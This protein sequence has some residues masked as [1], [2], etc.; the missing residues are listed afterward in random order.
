M[1]TR[2]LAPDDVS[3]LIDLVRRHSGIVL[4]PEKAYLFESRLLPVANRFDC[5]DLRC[6]IARLRKGANRALVDATVDA[7][8]INETS[9][10]R[11]SRP[12]DQFRRQLLP[13]L[14]ERRA[15]VRRLR[16]WSAAAST[17]Q[18][19]YSLAM[20]IEQYADRLRGWQ[21]EIL[22]SD[23]SASAIARAK[24][25]AYSQFEVQRG[26]P[27]PL[28]VRFFTQ[29]GKQWQVKPE[30]KKYVRFFEHNLLS[31]PSF[32]GS[33][34][35]VFLRNVLIYMDEATR[36]KIVRH[37]LSRLAP[38]GYLVVGSTESLAGLV[39]ELE[40]VPGA[41]AVY[42]PRAAATAGAPSRT[43]EGTERGASSTGSPTVRTGV[44]PFALG[45]S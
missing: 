41:H 28:L 21:I 8:T 36:R 23:I 45:S 9:F 10:F 3:F 1:T 43:A 33:V 11:D 18:E 19:A 39:P 17:G 31:P 29:N 12:F 13:E 4:P 16:L 7:M 15:R 35:V 2:Q 27:A 22:A 42:R 40:P 44:R 24:E 26:V 32:A 6:L 14:V 5:T 20:C 38:D 37:I 34:D 25:G 30:L